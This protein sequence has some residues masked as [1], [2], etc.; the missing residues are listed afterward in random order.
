MLSGELSTMTCVVDPPP[1]QS[2]SLTLDRVG[3]CCL[4]G[5]ICEYAY[6]S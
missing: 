1:L 5:L 3:E 6:R 4:V 2:T